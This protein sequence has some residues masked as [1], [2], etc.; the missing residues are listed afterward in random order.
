MLKMLSVDGIVDHHCLSF[1]LIKFLINGK[2][3]QNEKLQID[4]CTSHLN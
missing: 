4:T 2:I 3:E 1:L